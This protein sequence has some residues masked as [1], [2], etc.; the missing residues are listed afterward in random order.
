MSLFSSPI[1]H[2]ANPP[3]TWQVHKVGRSWDLRTAGGV[4]LGSFERRR[5]AEAGRTEGFYANLYA[6][7]TRWYA[8]G[9][10]DGWKPYKPV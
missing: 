1:E 7:E 9:Q 4:T 6:K 8:G 3:D 5:D 10:V 2:A